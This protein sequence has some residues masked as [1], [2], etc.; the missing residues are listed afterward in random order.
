MAEK[1]SLHLRFNALDV[2][3]ILLAI[4][5]I[6]GVFQRH[7]IQNLFTAGDKTES[8]TVTFEISK[9][10]SSS[11]E[12]LETG[13]TLYTENGGERIVLGTI[14][15]NVAVSPAVEYL[16]DGDG[17]TV[18]AV[19]PEDRYEH[20]LRVDGKLAGEG[21]ERNGIFLLAGKMQLFVNQT[22]TAHTET[23]DFEL[24][25]VQIEKAS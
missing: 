8:Y 1:K 24:R 16:T 10:R 11:M 6:V 13:T 4:L 2:V 9:I 25:I 12:L 5:C 19:Y 7:N 18:K 14:S 21:V 17:N 15:E 22:L 3:L 23:A 20:Y